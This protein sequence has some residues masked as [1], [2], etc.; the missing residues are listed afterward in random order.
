MNLPKQG[1][2]YPRDAYWT[3]FQIVGSG[4]ARAAGDIVVGNA[5]A[6]QS[7]GYYGD[8]MVGHIVQAD[9]FDLDGVGKGIAMGRPTAGF[10]TKLFVVT[11][12][13][14][15]VNET[16]IDTALSNT[17]RRRGGRIKVVPAD[18]YVQARV[19]G[20]VAAAK[21]GVGATGS[22]QLDATNTNGYEKYMNLILGLPTAFAHLLVLVGPAN[23]AQVVA[24]A[25]ESKAGTGVDLLNVQF[26]G[27]MCQGSPQ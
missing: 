12:V 20:A 26:G 9:P 6:T 21:V 17:V 15:S 8:L 2:T 13:P 24:L 25:M 1:N 4:A 10:N 22:L 5:S 27:L 16:F 11:D 3:G 7:G 14:K 19:I 18:S 23:A